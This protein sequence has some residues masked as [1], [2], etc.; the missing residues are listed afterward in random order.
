VE[1]ISFVA[2]GRYHHALS[3]LRIDVQ[4]YWGREMLVV[5]NGGLSGSC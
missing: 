2:D 4:E 1:G 3:G 5:L